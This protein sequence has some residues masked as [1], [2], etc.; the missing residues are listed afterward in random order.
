MRIPS[1]RASSFVLASLLAAASAAQAQ[2]I[3]YVGTLGGA[4]SPA[5]NFNSAGGSNSLAVIGT[6]VFQV[7]LGG[8]GNSLNSN[9]QVNADN[10]NGQGHYCTSDGWFSPNGV[11]VTADVACFDAAGNP[12]PADFTL[13]YQARTSKPPSGSIAFLWADQPDAPQFTAYTPAASYNFNSTGGTNTVTRENVGI[14]QAFLP[15]FTQKGNPQ[16]TAYGS[17]AARCEIANWFQNRVGTTVTVVCVNAAGVDTNEFFSLS[18]TLG[19]TEAAG[20]AATALGAYAWA[21]NAT[22][23]NYV[24]AKG[25]QLNTISP[26][27]P[28]TAQRFGGLVPGQYSLTVANPNNIGFTTFLGMVT[29]NGT[30]GEYCDTAG[31]VNVPEGELYQDLICY[32]AQGRQVDTPYTGTLMFSR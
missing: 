12:L 4:I 7:T 24:P 16:V 29:A 19:T 18:Y 13:F 14:Y 10:T 17:G 6:G 30:S 32:D 21:N 31:G 8:L 5:V 20:P 22:R 28:L 3:G 9:V 23:K 1:F 27:V 11:D 15:G 2:S 25:R 26:G